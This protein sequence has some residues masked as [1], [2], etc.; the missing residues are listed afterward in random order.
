MITVSA[1][2]KTNLTLEV[3]GKRPDGYH[4]IRSVVQTISLCDTLRL[5]AHGSVVAH[6][7]T[8]GWD[9]VKSLVVRAALLLKESARYAGGADITVEKRIPMMAG[10]GGD[11]S[12]AAAVLRGLNALWSL[13]WTTER[14]LPLAAQL[15]S[16]VAFF[17]HGGTCLMSGR[18]ESIEPLPPLP[19]RWVLV[20]N[21]AT[22]HLPGKTAAAYAALRP[23]HFTDGAITQRLADDLRAGRGFNSAHLF[24]T[25][26]NVAFAPGTELAVYRSHIRKIGAPQV[27]LAGSGPALYMLLDD[28]AQASDLF[29]RLRDQGMETFLCETAATPANVTQM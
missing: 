1:C 5:E 28:C 23:A 16:D 2:A 18:G 29:T 3:L 19:H 14:L 21:P 8:S 11:S 7:P 24:N 26:E 6:S 4:E 17:L 9:A 13:G 12:D 15:G 27:N 22:P 25:F 20:V 10:L